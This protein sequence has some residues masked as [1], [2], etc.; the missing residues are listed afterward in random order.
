LEDGVLAFTK[1]SLHPRH[2]RPFSG[3]GPRYILSVEIDLGDIERGLDVAVHGEP[4]MFAGEDLSPT[5]GSFSTSYA[6]LRGISGVDIRD[7]MPRRFDFIFQV[8]LKLAKIPAIQPPP[9]F[10]RFLR[11]A[12]FE[13]FLARKRLPN[14][15]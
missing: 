15:R 11:M 5:F 4:T 14:I 1:C 12:G 9:Q 3:I 10:L 8:S 7:R 2:L 6:F 13:S